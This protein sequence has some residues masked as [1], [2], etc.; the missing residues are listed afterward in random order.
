MHRR[1][2]WDMGEEYQRGKGSRDWEKGRLV[3]LRAREIERE[4][5]K[6]RVRKREGGTGRDKYKNKYR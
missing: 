4:G 3:K 2:V 5:K 6:E 1:N